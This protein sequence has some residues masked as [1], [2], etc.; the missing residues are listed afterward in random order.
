MNPFSNNKSG[1]LCTKCNFGIGHFNDNI[2]LLKAAILYLE[3]SA[4][5]CPIIGVSSN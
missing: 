4:A 2:E 5:D 3:K 1:L